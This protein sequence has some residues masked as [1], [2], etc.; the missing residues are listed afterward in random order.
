MEAEILALV[1]GWIPGAFV[2]WC[3]PLGTVE[4]RVSA[5]PLE[6][7]EPASGKPGGSSLISL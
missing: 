4:R 3:V 6:S 7:R 5:E 1:A 2:R